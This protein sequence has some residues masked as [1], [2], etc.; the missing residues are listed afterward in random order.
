MDPCNASKNETSGRGSHPFLAFFAL[1]AY[2]SYINFRECL[3]KLKPCDVHLIELYRSGPRSTLLDVYFQTGSYP[4]VRV[5]AKSRI[6]LDFYSLSRP[7][8]SVNF[9]VFLSKLHYVARLDG[10]YRL[11]SHLTRVHVY[12]RSNIP[13]TGS[14]RSKILGMVLFFSGQILSTLVKIVRLVYIK[15]ANFNDLEKILLN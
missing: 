11:V 12:F 4:K 6:F 7:A 2:H 3:R 10:L 5:W 14:N 13:K 15:G 1:K 9:A 8:I